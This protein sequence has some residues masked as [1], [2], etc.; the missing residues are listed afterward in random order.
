MVNKLKSST[1]YILKQ[2]KKAVGSTIGWP[3]FTEVSCADYLT[4]NTI[5][6]ILGIKKPKGLN[7]QYSRLRFAMDSKSNAVAV[8]SEFTS[9][10]AYITSEERCA[11][12][13]DIAVSMGATL[14]IARKQYKDYP[15]LVVDDPFE[16]YCKIISALRK[17]FSPKQISITGSIGKTSATQMVYTV[18]SS[19]F[20]THRNTGNANTLRLCGGVIQCLKQSHEAYVQ[21]VMEGPPCGSAST[22]SKL[23]QPQCAVVTKIGSSHMEAFGSQ[24]RILESCLGIQDGMPEDGLLILNADDPFQWQGRALCSRRVVYYG[25]DREEADYRAVNLRSEGD[26]RCFDVKYGDELVPVRI[27]CFGRH[28]VLNALA[29]FAAGKWAGL[30]DREIADGLEKYRTS[31]IRQNLVKHGGYRLYL[32]CYNSSLESIAVALDTFAEI[33]ASAGGRHIGVLADVAEVGSKAEEYHRS[34]GKLAGN[35]CL[36]LLICYGEDARFIQEEAGNCGRIPVYYAGT[37]DELLHLIRTHITPADV[38]LFKG[39]HCMELEHAVDLIWGTWYHEEFERCDLEPH[40]ENDKDFVYQV[41]TDHVTVVRKRSNAADLT[42]PKEVEGLPVTGIES[43]VFKGSNLAGTVKLLPGLVNIRNRAFYQ[44][45][46]ITGLEIPSSVRIIDESAFESCKNLRRVTI[47]DGCTH[48]GHRAFADCTNL[49]EMILPGSV[50]QID[51]E[52]FLHCEKLTICAPKGSP[53]ETYAFNHG[54]KFQ[55]KDQ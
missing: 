39:S 23:V 12:L 5:C 14:L 41:Y 22:I 44:A 19:K 10:P 38:T 29:A 51:E 42:L 26:W 49:E 30:T 18:I 37:R 33:P 2:A 45:N 4:L 46:K 52:A 7:Q 20:N 13:A 48:L 34:I 32:D 3:S 21:E 53:A 47:E 24:E 55:E 17:K 6:S 8:V 31:S 43:G 9:D 40:I 50:R 28:N 54:I 35:S 25:I 1:Y 11:E 27:C 16:A 36:D 15:T